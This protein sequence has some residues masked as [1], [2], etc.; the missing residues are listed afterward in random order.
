ME[1]FVFLESFKDNQF[2][3]VLCSCQHMLAQSNFLNLIILEF[4][5]GVLLVFYY[6]TAQFHTFQMAVL[7][8]LAPSYILTRG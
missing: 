3:R 1:D 5:L 7:I 6:D 2:K 4:S 8:A